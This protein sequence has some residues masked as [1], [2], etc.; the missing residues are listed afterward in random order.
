MRAAGE[1]INMPPRTVGVFKQLKSGAVVVN[2]DSMTEYHG[3][4][5]T[6]LTDDESCPFESPKK[7][8]GAHQLYNYN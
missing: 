7:R 8:P 6:N 5:D 2:T 1:H 3:V 4:E